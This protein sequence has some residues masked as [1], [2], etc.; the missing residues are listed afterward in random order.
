MR[1]LVFVLG[2][3]VTLGIYASGL[4]CPTEKTMFLLSNHKPRPANYSRFSSL[5]GTAFA[6]ALLE[7]P[8]LKF[9]NHGEEWPAVHLHLADHIA[10]ETRQDFI[11]NGCHA[12]DF[13]PAIDI[14]QVGA[15]VGRSTSLTD[16]VFTLLGG[17]TTNHLAAVLVEPLPSSFKNLQA[18]YRDSKARIS[19]ENV[20]LVTSRDLEARGP[21]C[22]MYIPK[23]APTIWG[24]ID[25]RELAS[26]DPRHSQNHGFQ[27]TPLQAVALNWQQLLQRHSK[28]AGAHEMPVG[29]LLLDTEG[30]DCRLLLDF[31]WQSLRSNVVMFEHVHCDGPNSGHTVVRDNSGEW[32]PA[33]R[34]LFDRTASVLRVY[35][36]TLVEQTGTDATWALPNAAA[37]ESAKEAEY[38]FGLRS[39]RE[40]A[41]IEVSPTT[42]SDEGGTGSSR[43]S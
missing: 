11:L 36:Y 32:V 31:P 9:L 28:Q 1:S 7:A 42:A 16:P 30:Y 4:E 26:L 37:M 18:N 3:L 5:F 25:S 38:F 41:G 22:T 20:A 29:M 43:K 13:A 27:A 35:G 23:T 14:L 33:Q 39:K 12:D 34:P 10:T 40:E 2:S 19:F 24:N 15:S 8:N 17:Q 21:T 6:S